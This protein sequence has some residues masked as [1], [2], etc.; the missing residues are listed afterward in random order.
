[1]CLLILFVFFIAALQ[2]AR[3]AVAHII[4]GYADIRCQMELVVIEWPESELCAHKMEKKLN[5]NDY[6]I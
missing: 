1:M 2:C 3:Q 4:I 6:Y 5:G